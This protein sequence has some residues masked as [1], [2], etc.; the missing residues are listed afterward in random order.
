MKRMLIAIMLLAAVPV[1]LAGMYVA[2]QERR[3]PVALDPV[4]PA[5][6]TEET[7]CE[8]TIE[9]DGRLV[10]KTGP[11]EEPTTVDLEKL[12]PGVMADRRVRLLVHSDA[13]AKSVADIVA[14]LKKVKASVVLAQVEPTK[15]QRSPQ[16]EG[17]A[18]DNKGPV[19]N[20][21]ATGSLGAAPVPDAASAP[22]TAPANRDVQSLRRAYRQLDRQAAELARRYRELEVD[23]SEDA[24]QETRRKQLRDVVA[25]QFSVRQEMQWAEVA[26]LRDRLSRL[27]QSIADRGQR[28]EQMIDRRV[29][30]LLDAES[31]WPVAERA[32]TPRAIPVHPDPEAEAA[33]R[34]PLVPKPNRLEQSDWSRAGDVKVL[35]AKLVAAEADWQRA[36]ALAATAAISQTEVDHLRSNVEIARAEL[37]KANRDLA[38]QQR[39]FRLDLEEAELRLEAARNELDSTKQAVADGTMPASAVARRTLEVRQAELAI[40]RAKAMLQQFESSAVK[41]DAPATP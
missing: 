39:L 1:V 15:Q 13:P 27:E 9:P 32:A 23:G 12:D 28:S 6:A 4:A 26:D 35:E 34:G 31:A 11:D 14:A 18:P 41:P 29:E 7:D 10:Y 37:D 20:Q 30:D 33:A 38:V 16:P 5:G 8:M 2:A 25:K 3:A 36:K 22:D 19:D 24:E 40:E 17:A 21:P